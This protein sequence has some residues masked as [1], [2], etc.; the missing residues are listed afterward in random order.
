MTQTVRED[1]LATVNAALAQV[2]G[3]SCVVKSLRRQVNIEGPVGL[4]AIGKAA[5]AMAEGALAVL[6]ERVVSGLLVSKGGCGSVNL[7]DSIMH[8]IGGHPAPDRRSI[9]AG[10]ILTQYLQNTATDMTLLFLISGGSSALVEVLPEHMSLKQLQQLNHYLLASGLSISEIN[11]VRQ[12]VSCIKAGRLANYISARKTVSLLMSDVVGNDTSVIGSGL[13]NASET[14]PDFAVLPEWIKKLCANSPPRPHAGS[15]VLQT[16]EQIIVADLD[17]ALSA[18]GIAASALGY[19]VFR[20]VEPIEGN[21][22]DCAKNIAACL[23]NAPAGIH[24]W[25]GESTVKLPEDAG[26][27]GRNTHLILALA[28]QLRGCQRIA[29]AAVATD[30]DDGNSGYA[31]AMIDGA[32]LIKAGI[33]SSAVAKSLQKADSAT[34]LDRA[35]ALLSFPKGRSN[36]ADLL[37]A[38]IC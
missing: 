12:C 26:N 38:I 8:C 24:L 7:P 36:V 16:I 31:G 3:K 11:A 1:L 13:L 17:T 37:L 28:E 9:E 4:M 10:V 35:G 23:L 6:G 2:D 27:G 19:Q 22:V 30:A 20:H 25:G 14:V 15:D 33:S 18:A 34:L 29:V 32:T 5:P 21:A